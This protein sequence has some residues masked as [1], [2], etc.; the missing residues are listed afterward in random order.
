MTPAPARDRPD[1]S[2]VIACYMEE[3]HLEDSVRQ[4]QEQLDA[5]GRSYEL[6]FVE[7][8]SRD[9]TAE[10]IAKLVAGKPNWRAVYHE[11]NV[12]RGGTVTE[13]FLLARGDVVGFLDIDLEV[14][15]RFLP[16]VL[17]AIDAGADGATAFRH[18]TVSKRPAALLRHFLSSGYRW[19]FRT[20]FDVPFRDPET[21]FKFFRRE[22]IVPV[23]KRTR[24]KG[25]FWDSEIMILAH[26]AGL[27]LVEVPCRF[28]RR[29]DKQSTVRIFRDVWKYLVAIRAFRARQRAEGKA[30]AAKA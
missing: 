6:I 17:A 20:L 29:A 2:V 25:W 12:G 22:P 23:A 21:G 28:E 1:L 11:Q 4:L 9:R 27:K 8:K 19:L 16:S 14:H 13:G 3:G 7:D 15:C 10:V 26:Q 24:D 18:Y 30:A 5:I